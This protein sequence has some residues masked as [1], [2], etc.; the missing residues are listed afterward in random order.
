MQA[1]QLGD[2]ARVRL[3][4]GRERSVLNRHPWIFSGAIAGVDGAPAVGG[5]VEVLASDGRWLARG[6]WSAKSQIRVRIWTWVQA[7][8]IDAALIGSRIGRAIAHRRR[9]LGSSADACRLVYSEA[10]GLPGLIADRYGDWVVVQVS[11][12]G[13]QARLDAVIDAIR[14]EVA[15]RGILERSEDDS[16]KR[17]GLKPRRGMLWGDEPAAEVEVVDGEVR[18]LVDLVDGQKTGGYLDQQENHRRVAAYA[19]GREFLSCFSYV[20]GFELHAARSGAI[21]VL[22]IDSSAPALALAERNRLRNGIETPIEWRRANVFE[23][24]RE[25]GHEGKR[26]DAVILDPPKLVPTR[27]N[28]ERGLRAYKDLNLHALRL[29]RPDGILATFSC[30]G[31]VDRDLFQKVVFGAAI[32]AGRD[33]QIVDRLGQPPDHPVLLNFPESDYM[34]GLVCRVL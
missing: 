10:D 7:E 11:T 16:L 5:A 8:P 13:M 23:A 14:D 25:L 29:L 2:S 28:L 18:W 33:V 17:E 32:N 12:A 1:V 27:A 9:M 20:G 22:G 19:D 26:F 3:L 24:L 34:K 4:A 6:T 15:P 21:S 30:S 31:H